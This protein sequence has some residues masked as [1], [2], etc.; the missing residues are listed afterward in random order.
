MLQCP[1]RTAFALAALML[2]CLGTATY[3][4]M[5]E[6][7]VNVCMVEMVVNMCVW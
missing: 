7:V 2:P 5:V 3:V 6:M 4:C 1:D